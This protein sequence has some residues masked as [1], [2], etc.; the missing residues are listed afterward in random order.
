MEEG[1]EVN[2]S[3]Y[4]T[5]SELLDSLGILWWSM[6]FCADLLLLLVTDTQSRE[7]IGAIE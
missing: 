5:D 1:G 6:L 2:G 3:I 4:I 7:V